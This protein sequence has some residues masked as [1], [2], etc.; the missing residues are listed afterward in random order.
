MT[1]PLVRLLKVLSPLSSKIIAD[2]EVRDCV[3][4][5]EGHELTTDL[6]ILDMTELDVILSMD[7]LL[8]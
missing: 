8:T 3:V 2:S 5:L 6:T 1:H 4:A 7:W